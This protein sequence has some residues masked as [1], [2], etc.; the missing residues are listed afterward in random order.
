MVDKQL[1][2][3]YRRDGVIC[4]K[5][6][7]ALWVDQLR[8]GMSRLI[9]APDQF[10]LTFENTAEAEAGRF[11]EGYVNWQ[12][13][14]EFKAFVEQSDAATVAAAL[15]GSD[16][17][18]FFHEHAFQ[19]EPGTA[20]ATPWH[21][22]I[23]YYPLSG[24]QNVSIYIA[25]DPVPAEQAIRFVKGSHAGP[26]FRPRAFREGRDYEGYEDIMESVPDVD[27]SFGDDRIAGW[28]LEPGDAI[29][30]HFAT[31]HG[32]PAAPVKTRRRAFSTRWL[33]DDVRYL[34]RPG[35]TSPPWPG[36]DLKTGDRLREDWFPVMKR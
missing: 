9:D 17:A 1:I 28:A 31:L 21:Q 8:D 12:H 11:F 26:V 15:M 14:R 13:V 24:E 32:V 3:D 35:K 22:D 19:R 33:G 2:D 4:L 27:S 18:Q 5:G 16:C 34:E 7:F 20:H 29:L 10:P 6:E 23:S 30:F 25:L 36:I